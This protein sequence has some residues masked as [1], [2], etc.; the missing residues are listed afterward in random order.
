MHQGAEIDIQA[1]GTHYCCHPS[2]NT[3]R[4]GAVPLK[5]C[6]EYRLPRLMKTERMRS[7]EGLHTAKTVIS[8]PELPKVTLWLMH[9]YPSDPATRQSYGK[10]P[11]VVLE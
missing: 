5:L 6:L 10:K 8:A 4:F 3:E 11:E 7:G 1:V 2:L 9:P